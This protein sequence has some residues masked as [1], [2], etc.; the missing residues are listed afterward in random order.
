M[1][2][3]PKGKSLFA[4][5]SS[6]KEDAFFQRKKGQVRRKRKLARASGDGARSATGVAFGPVI[7][8]V[9]ASYLLQTFD[10]VLGPWHRASP[11]S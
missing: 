10:S 5:F 2:P 3:A 6:E 9:D 8:A 1:H 11:R 4:S 7:E